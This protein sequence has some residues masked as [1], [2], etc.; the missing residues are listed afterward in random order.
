MKRLHLFFSL[1]TALL[2]AFSIMLA[3]GTAAFVQITPAFAASSTS[4]TLH[5]HTKARSSTPHFFKTHAIG[6]N[7]KTTSSDLLTYNGGPI[8]NSS[9][10]YAIFWEP[11]TLQD[12][13]NTQVSPTYNSLLQNYFGDIGGS[14]LYG[15]NTQ[16]Y[17]TNG[18]IANNSTFGGAW[19]DTS[20]YPT[21]L[22]DDSATP[23]DC[24]TDTQIQAEVAKAMTANNWTG[25]LT[26]MFFVFTSS[27]EGSCFDTSSTSCSFTQYCAYHGFFSDNNNQPIVYANMPYTGTNLNA[28]GV[29][30]SPNND[31]DAD[32]TINV[33][34]HE[35]ME[36]V[37]DPELNAW[38]D[39]QGNEIG[40]KCAWNFGTP[41]LD[42]DQANVQWN[43]HYYIVQQEWSNAID[44]CTLSSSTP[45]PAGGVAYV[46]S[47]DG[48]VYAVNTNDGTQL[49]KAKT[50]GAVVS[51]PV[52]VNNTLYVGSRDRYVYALNA[53]TGSLL[54]RTRTG[55]AI[56]SSPQ[57]V[58]GTL[59]IGSA[60]GTFYALNSSNGS[61][62]WRFKTG[63]SILTTP[64][65][66]SNVAYVSSS[67][68]QL[69]ALNAGN[70]RML[71]HTLIRGSVFATPTVT[72]GIA[73]AGSSSGF[74]LAFNAGNGRVIWR[75]R[76]SGSVWVAPAVVN[77][78]LYI[79]AGSGFLYAI[80]AQKGYLLWRYHTNGSI[81]TAATIDSNVIYVGSYDHNLYALDATKG[82][83]IWH[84]QTG[85]HILS[86]PASAG[87]VIYFGSDDRNL[88]ALSE[89]NAL[90]S[91]HY[92]T[93][94]QVESSPAVVLPPA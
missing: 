3:L 6:H 5:A 69:Y 91:W 27:G 71:W 49:W 14:G 26:H 44:G 55:N 8:M 48:S 15:N 12:G 17:D 56:Y 41:S 64:A 1:H 83:L 92:L 43:S 78:V 87:G 57:I 77:N 79:G 2:F 31:F 47:N 30:T 81:G 18:H 82:S 45:P 32:S 84:Y 75:F 22:C 66:A 53:S 25:G 73:Y 24:I 34:S 94:G 13:S 33:T 9:V 72:N 70:G 80:N 10:T 86:T 50:G 23:L 85:G 39:A 21:S 46:G 89:S 88:Y 68:G 59:F 61:I 35:H 54:W 58:N 11:T 67:N 74:V 38:Y 51:S 76:T 60:D 20:A 28:C 90:L 29:S 16:Y 93:G 36:A 42:N 62:Q 7:S 37:T 52:V 65:I 4:T 19:T 40:D 63:S